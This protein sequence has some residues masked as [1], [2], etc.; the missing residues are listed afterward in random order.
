MSSYLGK[1][2]PGHSSRLVPRD[3]GVDLLGPKVDAAFEVLQVPE[4]GLVAEELQRFLASLAALAVEDDLLVAVQLGVALGEL[5]QRDQ[6]RAVQAGD[7]PFL[8]V[9]DVQDV[10]MLA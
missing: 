1:P 5:V 6:V 3:A 9:A 2:A 10:G 4:A 8:R 7:L